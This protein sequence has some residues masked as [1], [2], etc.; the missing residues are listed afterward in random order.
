LFNK[1]IDVAKIM[2]EIKEK[3]K[4][5]SK[6]KYVDSEMLDFS[7]NKVLSELIYELN[8]INSYIENTHRDAKNYIEMGSNI[9]VA[10]ERPWIIRK[11]LM[12][13][14]RFFRK[15]TRFL[16]L[17]QTEFNIRIM[18]C[19]KAIHE[20]Q[21]CVVSAVNELRKYRNDY[22][23]LKLKYESLAK[24]ENRDSREIID[25]E[26]Y[27]KFENT[28]R[29]SEEEIKKRLWN[30]VDYVVYKTIED[31]ND[32]LIIDLGCGRGEFLEILRAERYNCI[33]V[34]LNK[35]SVKKCIDKDLNVICDNGLEY[36][37]SL[38]DSSVKIITG[39]QLVEH[40][41]LSEIL[42]LVKECH[43]VL[44]DGGKII[45]ET[46]NS[47]NLEVGA[48]AFYNDPTHIRPVNQEYL[49]FLCDNAGYSDTEIY[50]WKNNEIE[51]WIN[52]VI[53]SDNTK[54]L[55]SSTVRMILDDLRKKM[56]ISP[57][58]AI[59]ATK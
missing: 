32:D 13:Y 48:Y 41:D 20:S 27:L 19:V 55:E 9:R 56:F 18:N 17:D 22:E 38:E 59:I 24:I 44:K 16:V 42:E 21:E 6:G 3:V 52:S 54:V 10:N 8:R 30:Y 11:F 39:F 26:T 57:D 23:N 7:D 5:E 47:K 53:E 4:K 31:K 36:L 28:F 12:L 45:F 49:K 40:L 1:E 58:Y 2:H 37:K 33:G 15:S 25:D 51:S 46:P 14:K 34:D 35:E 50:Y 43:R 29:G